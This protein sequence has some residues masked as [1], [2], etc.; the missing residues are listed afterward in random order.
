MNA[1]PGGTPAAGFSYQ[2]PDSRGEVAAWGAGLGVP[3][4]AIGVG[5]GS[6]YML[7]ARIA[8]RLVEK[9]TWEAQEDAVS[10]WQLFGQ[11]GRVRNRRMPGLQPDV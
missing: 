10:R 3:G 11:L 5:S 4:A 6:Q 1:L 2:P 8:A 7:G 9:V